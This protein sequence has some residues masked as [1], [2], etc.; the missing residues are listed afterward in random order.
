MKIADQCI[1]QSSSEKLPLIENGKQHR[2]PHWTESERLWRENPA[3]DAMP[4]S[5]PSLKD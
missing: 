2:E 5:N 1:S 3:P 4:L